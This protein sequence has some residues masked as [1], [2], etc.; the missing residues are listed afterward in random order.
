MKENK[1]YVYLHKEKI[2]GAVFYVG[3][4]QR[5]RLRTKSGRNTKWNEFVRENEWYSEIYAANL[6]SLEALDLESKLIDE[7]KPSCN[8]TVKNT[9]NKELNED[10]LMKRYCYDENCPTGLVY[11]EW[12]GQYGSRRKNKGDCAGILNSNG[13]FVVFQSGSGSVMAHRVVY[14][15][16][17]GNFDSQ[18]TIDHIDGNRQNNNIRNLRLVTTAEN[19]KNKG[20]RSK[21]QTG[22]TGVFECNGFYQISA[23]E[24]DNKPI[25][26]QVSIKKFGRDLAFKLACYI[27]HKVIYNSGYSERH[28]GELLSI[29]EEYSEEQVIDMLSDRKTSTNKSGENNVCFHSV[30]GNS[31]WVFYYKKNRRSFSVTKYGNDLARALAVEYRNRFFG[32]EPNVVINYSITETDSML[33]ETT[34]A[35]NSSGFKGI[36]FYHNKM[37][38]LYIRAQ[39]MVDY[40]NYSKI[41]N[42]KRL[43]IMEAFAKAQSWIESVK[44][45]IC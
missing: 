22:V 5:S 40:K 32:G 18:M 3:K 17:N 19:C 27:R 26:S 16:N 25:K 44:E 21:N 6:S 39:I 30:R 7:L 36:V 15:L 34:S 45:K 37:D 23:A 8:I 2:S 13:Y 12:N 14:L 29:L 41:F 10:F 31:F 42:C 1:Y 33:N 28:S 35:A 24:N 4:G 11:N 20:L 43:G 38:S 9:K